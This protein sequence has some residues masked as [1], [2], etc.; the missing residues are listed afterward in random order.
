MPDVHVSTTL[1]TVSAQDSAASALACASMQ[2]LPLLGGFA[3]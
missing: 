1:R 3:A 2:W